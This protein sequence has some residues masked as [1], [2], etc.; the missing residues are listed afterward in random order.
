[1]G[2][3]HEIARLERTPVILGTVNNLARLM[4]LTPRR[5]QQLAKAGIIAQA[6]RGG[7]DIV[8]CLAMYVAYLEEW[9]A[10]AK[11]P[12]SSEDLAHFLG[13]TKRQIL[14]LSRNGIIP[15]IAPGRFDLAAGIQSY[16]SFIKEK[17]TEGSIERRGR[18]A[19][20]QC[21]KVKSLK[22]F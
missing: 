4:S 11:I 21:P 18:K 7:Y 19:P 6:G 2:L 15:A 17:Y 5:V 10:A 9:R 1:M 13:L 16:L 8:R 22:L 20:W 12:C 3:R 14:Y